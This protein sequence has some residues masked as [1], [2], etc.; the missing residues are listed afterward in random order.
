MEAD[1][2][3]ELVPTEPPSV[4]VA[5]GAKVVWKI[6]VKTELDHVCATDWAVVPDELD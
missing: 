1:T 2:P 5:D 6:D 4:P 3:K